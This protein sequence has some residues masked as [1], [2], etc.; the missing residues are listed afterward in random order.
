MMMQT[1]TKKLLRRRRLGRH[2]SGTALVE[3]ALAAPVLTLM[4]VGIIE[5]ARWAGYAVLAES[6][7]WFGA[8]YG[9]FD[10]TTAANTANMNSYTTG[11]AEFLPSGYTYSVGHVC[12]VNGAQPPTTCP[13]FATNPPS[14]T[15]YYVKITVTG[16]YTP[17]ITL[18]AFTNVLPQ[19]VKVQGISY[20]QVQ[21]Q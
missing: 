18:P 12:S 9:S 16:T 7:A 19:S 4:F 20:R 17:L 13:S 10:L 5:G 8:T 3:F 14:N 11:A 15:V 21:T 2:E 6:G 1:L